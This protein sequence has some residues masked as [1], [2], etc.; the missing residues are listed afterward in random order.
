LT[1][2]IFGDAGENLDDFSFYLS[3][4]GENFDDFPSSLAPQAKIWMFFPSDSAPQV[5]FLMDFLHLRRR[6]RKF[7]FFPFRFSAAGEKM[8]FSFY[9]SA[10]GELFDDFSSSPAPQ[11][12]IWIFCLQ[13]QRRRRNF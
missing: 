3:A 7:G 12:K 10:A 6:R 1:S 4:A 13:I 11:A 2:F 9:L 5:N 8:D